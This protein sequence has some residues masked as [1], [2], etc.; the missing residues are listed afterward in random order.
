MSHYTIDITREG[1]FWLI[2]IPELN[3]IT[4]A[5]TW[6]EIPLM[7]TEFISLM[8]GE[9]RENITVNIHSVTLGDNTSVNEAL[10][11]RSIAREAD[12]KAAILTAQAARTLRDEGLPLREV[13]A[14]LGVSHQRAAQLCAA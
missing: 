8:T 1:K 13:G 9:S 14:V 6:N 3:G 12:E 10:R 2:H 11:A 7:A 5:Y 4:Q